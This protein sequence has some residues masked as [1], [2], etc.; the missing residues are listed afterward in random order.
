MALSN[1]SDLPTLSSPRQVNL[2]IG[3]IPEDALPRMAK[4]RK[5]TNREWPKAVI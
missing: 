5:I 2:T 4:S 1:Q 3:L